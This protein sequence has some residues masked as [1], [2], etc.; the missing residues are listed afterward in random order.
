MGIYLTLPS[1]SLPITLENFKRLG[2]D[3][4]LLFSNVLARNPRKSEN[5]SLF[6]K[7]EI[8][9]EVRP[10]LLIDL[11]RILKPTVKFWC[12]RLPST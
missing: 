1:D 5:S 8:L 9:D 4:E 2:V 7:T 10:P 6:G 12:I 11:P 3:L